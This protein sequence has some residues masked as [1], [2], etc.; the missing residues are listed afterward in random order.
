MVSKSAGN[1]LKNTF[2]TRSEEMPIGHPILIGT[3]YVLCLHMCERRESIFV[4][5]ISRM[6]PN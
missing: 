1:L 4:D 5:I 6:W 2:V 3:D